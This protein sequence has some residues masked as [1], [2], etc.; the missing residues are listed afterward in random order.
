MPGLDLDLTPRLGDKKPRPKATVP[1][2]AEDDFSQ[3][4]GEDRERR[5]EAEQRSRTWPRLVTRRYHWTRLLAGH[6]FQSTQQGPVGAKYWE[7]ENGHR[8]F[9]GYIFTE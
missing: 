3:F 9:I 4:L 8:T 6:D 2:K 5:K 7:Y 1:N